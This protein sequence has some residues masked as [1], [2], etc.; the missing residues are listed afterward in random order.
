MLYGVMALMSSAIFRM[1]NCRASCVLHFCHCHFHHVVIVVL[2][3]QQK[4]P[5]YHHLRHVDKKFLY[6]CLRRHYGKISFFSPSNPILVFHHQQQK[7]LS[8]VCQ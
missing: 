8:V 1:S 3:D 2:C 5:N 4:L 7:L 6:F